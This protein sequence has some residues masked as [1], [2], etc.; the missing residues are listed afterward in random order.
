MHRSSTCRLKSI[1]DAGIQV[2]NGTFSSGRGGKADF[3]GM[4]FFKN[5]LPRRAIESLS[6]LP[7]FRVL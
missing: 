7:I 1:S 3:V 5:K 6:V 4:T 2:I